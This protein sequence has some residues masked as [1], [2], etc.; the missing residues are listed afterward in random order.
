VY[1]MGMWMV[2]KGT[3]CM[4]WECGWSR[5]VPRVPVVEHVTMFT[6]VFCRQVKVSEV[7]G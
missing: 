3:S 7:T 1:G 5:E 6:A 2:W 4:E